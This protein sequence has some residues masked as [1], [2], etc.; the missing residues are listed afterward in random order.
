MLKKIIVGY[1]EA[2]YWTEEEHLGREAGDLSV[3]AHC[4]IENDVRCFVARAGDLFEDMAP[5]QIGHDFWL[6][7]NRHGA[8]FWDRGLGERGDRLSDIAKE[9]GESW[10]YL[11][12]EGYVCL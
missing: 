9:F 7:R 1:I 12:D 11:D 5:E 10:P 2:L 3:A 4:S 6:T 8:G